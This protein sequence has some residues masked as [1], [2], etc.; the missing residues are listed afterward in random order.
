MKHRILFFALCLVA[1]RPSLAAFSVD[2]PIVS[3]TTGSSTTFF[4]A[5]DVT[6][7]TSLTTDVT[8]EYIATDLSVDASG[9]LA[10]LGA[11]GNFHADDILTYLAS[12]NAITAAQA[13]GFGTMLIGFS[14]ASF[15]TG[16]EASVTARVYNFLNSGQKPSV[17]LAYRGLV[18]RKNGAHTISSVINNTTGLT[19]ATPSVITNV[20]LENVGIDDSGAVQT[21]VIT[22]KATFYD[23][24]NGNVVGSQPTF[25]LGAGQMTQVN[26]IWKSANLPADATTLIMSVA[27]TAGTATIRG[28]V[29]VKD[30]NTNDGAFFFME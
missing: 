6:N 17:G 15:T 29:V 10:T 28:Y 11:Y 2:L 14:S 4:T 9:K 12:Q 1:A 5:L 30:T 25:S 20:G 26:D 18:L 13:N 7:H 21:D 8:F 27:E 23:P 16:S 22:L 3:H 19:D 24:K